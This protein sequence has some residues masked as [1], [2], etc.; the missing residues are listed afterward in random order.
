MVVSSFSSVTICFM[1]I[2]TILVVWAT[3]FSWRVGDV[4]QFVLVFAAP[5]DILVFLVFLVFLG[6]A[7]DRQF[8]EGCLGL[9]RP[10]GTVWLFD[11]VPPLELAWRPVGLI[12]QASS[13]NSDGATVEFVI[14]VMGGA[15]S[16]TEKLV[17]KIACCSGSDGKVDDVTVFDAFLLEELVCSFSVLFCLFV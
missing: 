9:S 5:N 8:T 13:F 16:D 17:L 12:L 2:L 14:F 7:S 15:A 6:D 10:C 4:W 1:E 3:A 11:C